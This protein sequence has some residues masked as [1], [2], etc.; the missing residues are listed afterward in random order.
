MS[1][2]PTNQERTAEYLKRF[3]RERTLKYLLHEPDPIIFD[4]GA[5]V[6]TTL[7]EFKGWWPGAKVHCFE[8]QEECWPELER[9]ASAFAR[10]SVIVNRCAA[11]GVPTEH[12]TFY[13]HDISN[14]ISGFHKINLD[15]LDSIDLNR[16]AEAGS[17]ALSDYERTLNH[18]R[19]V[20]VIRL[21]DYIAKSGI[22]RVHL[23]K[24]DTQGFEPE[25][26]DGLGGRLRDVDVVISELMFYDY[27]ERSLSFSSLEQLLI[28][29]GFRLYDISHIAKNPMN[30]RTD[31][32]DVIYVHERL[33]YRDSGA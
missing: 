8:P 21:D 20:T 7:D 16:M 32:V 6:G 12:A 17:A 24:M 14:A 31:W 22:K 10:G 13:S 11:G 1:K 25:V 29:A 19:T 9:R 2:Y 30:G 27:Y 5:N 23:L 4:V 33:R 3:D 28:P 15:S 26:L 18:E